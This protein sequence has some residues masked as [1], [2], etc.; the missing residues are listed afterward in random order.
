MFLSLSRAIFDG[1]LYIDDALTIVEDSPQIR[2]LLSVPP[3]LSLRGMPFEELI[4]T[5]RDKARFREFILASTLLRADSGKD[6]SPAALLEVTLR[7]MNPAHCDHSVYY[8]RL[9]LIASGP[10]EVYVG[11]ENL[12][13]K[14]DVIPPEDH[15]ASLGAPSLIQ[16]EIRTPSIA[17]ALDTTHPLSVDENLPGI[18][19]GANPRAPPHVSL[20]LMIYRALNQD[21]VSM[22]SKTHLDPTIGGAGWMTMSF[23]VSDMDAIREDAVRLL[24]HSEQEKFLHADKIGDLR[25]VSKLFRNTTVGNFD[26]TSFVCDNLSL[27]SIHYICGICRY[28]IGNLSR[29][30][31]AD[32]MPFFD[33]WMAGYES[34]N[35]YCSSMRSTIVLVLISCCIERPTVMGPGGPAR[36]DA[37]FRQMISRTDNFGLTDP[38]RL[39]AVYSACLLYARLLVSLPNKKTEAVKILESAL[40]D[41]EVFRL[42]H[43]GSRVIH[44]IQAYASFNRASLAI[45]S[46]DLARATYWTSTLMAGSRSVM[47][48]TLVSILKEK[49]FS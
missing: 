44:E 15:A 24:K 11:I 2:S 29:L 35:V 25:T 43:P 8:T 4:F 26:V 20:V 37:M 9:Y 5:D 21:I 27:A 1:F 42:R 33:S 34:Q 32:F 23:E 10:D 7:S 22:L 39:V 19:Y 41:M 6:P 13:S 3:S 46:G 38:V 17:D 47:K 49:I 18:S 16:R 14:T 28:T 40:E 30:D 45:E 36:L 12:L 48:D 31:E